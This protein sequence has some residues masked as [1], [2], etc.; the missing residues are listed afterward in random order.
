MRSLPTATIPEGLYGKVLS[1]ALY[2]DVPPAAWRD[3]Q[4]LLCNSRARVIAAQKMCKVGP[5]THIDSKWRIW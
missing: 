5:K 3:I 2:N 4:G 1:W